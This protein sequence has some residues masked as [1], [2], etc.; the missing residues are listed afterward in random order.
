MEKIR[1]KITGIIILVIS[2]CCF[3]Q[4]LCTENFLFNA[5][6]S[7]VDNQGIPIDWEQR[8]KN[9]VMGLA[10]ENGVLKAWINEGG[11]IDACE[12]DL[13]LGQQFVDTRAIIGSLANDTLYLRAW[14]KT[15][16]IQVPTDQELLQRAFTCDPD[17]DTTGTHYY[18]NV[19]SNGGFQLVV[20]EASRLPGPPWFVAVEWTPW[21][22][23]NGTAI[24]DWE[25]V[26]GKMVLRDDVG[27]FH[28]WI[29]LRSASQCTVWVDNIQISSDPD[30]CNE[31][32][33]KPGSVSNKLHSKA[34]GHVS[35]FS[36]G[37]NTIHFNQTTSYSLS[38]YTPTGKLI[39]RKSGYESVININEYKLSSGAYVIDLKSEVGDLHKSII[40][41]DR[42]M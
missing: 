27:H 2:T 3:A 38:I 34:K 39:V 24:T 6:F 4:E 17:A 12:Q 37:N 30:F 40:I 8:T 23:H 25:A 29:L 18:H 20:Q 5:H 33:E 10:V 15:T 41:S 14:V 19:N 31:P 21:F 35:A 1:L 7:E 22:D 36:T 28:F 13:I 42:N 11:N 16:P 9:D 32:F 26:N